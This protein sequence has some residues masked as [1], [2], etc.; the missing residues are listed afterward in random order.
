MI[1][2]YLA[3]CLAFGSAQEYWTV[4]LLVK[5]EHKVLLKIWCKDMYVNVCIHVHIKILKTVKM[6]QLFMDG[7]CILFT[8]DWERVRVVEENEQFFWR[9]SIF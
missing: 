2:K 3:E 9:N 1:I 5:I 8:F 6:L 4:V 7:L